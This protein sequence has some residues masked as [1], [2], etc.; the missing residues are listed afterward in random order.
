MPVAWNLRR[1]LTLSGGEIA[2]DV[3]GYGQPLIL[4]HG[5]P[6]RSYIWRDVAMRL[7]DRFTVYVFDLLGFGQAERRTRRL[8]LGPVTNARRTNR[9]LGARGA[10]GRRP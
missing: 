5:T 3:L 6:T 8:Y 1:R 2:Y 4:V 7:A 10:L 9:G